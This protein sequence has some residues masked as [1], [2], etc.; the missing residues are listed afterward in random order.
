MRRFTLIELLI[1]VAIIG[2]LV[3]ILLPSLSKAR[4]KALFVVCISQRDQLYKGMQLGL[5]DNDYI[6]PMIRGMN[7]TN[8]VDPDWEKD[9]W[10]GASRPNDGQLINGVIEQYIPDYRTI[11]R[12]P[13][14]PDGT[15]GDQTGSNGHFD[16]THP[17][18]FARIKFARID[19]VMQAN[20]RELPTLWITEENPA[21]VNGLWKEG[22]FA[23][24]DKIG[25]WHDNGKKGGYISIDGVSVIMRNHYNNF[26]ANSM[27][28]EYKG[29]IKSIRQVD[30]LE[31]W[32]RIY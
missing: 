13:S 14:L 6:T 16:Y 21:T 19:T 23:N 11:T 7:Y 24:K 25:S 30:T 3:S 10:M 27:T 2:I 32:P 15:P 9:D 18:S 12:C 26:S 29:V 8:P 20:S 1:V 4:E 28:M 17:Y 22:A 31:A 5:K